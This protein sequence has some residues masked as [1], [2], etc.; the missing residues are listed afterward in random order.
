MVTIHTYVGFNWFLVTIHTYA[1][2]NWFLSYRGV[3]YNNFCTQNAKGQVFWRMF[4]TN[5]AWM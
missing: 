1:S 3:N 5:L 4:P 2:F